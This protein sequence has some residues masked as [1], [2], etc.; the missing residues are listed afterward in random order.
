[1]SNVLINEENLFPGFWHCKNNGFYV[2]V[3]G[4]GRLINF[5][6]GQIGIICFQ[7]ILVFRYGG[8]RFPGMATMTALPKL[9]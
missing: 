8:Q 9:I 7:E 1:M 2:H 5:A 3:P 6:D 4:F